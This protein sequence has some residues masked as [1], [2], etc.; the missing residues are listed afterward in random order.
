MTPKQYH[1]EVRRTSTKQPREHMLNVA[2]LGITLS[3]LMELN[4]A[5]MLRRYPHGFTSRASIERNDT[6]ET[7]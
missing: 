4:T 1:A 3:D 7:A 2:A 6:K 5:K